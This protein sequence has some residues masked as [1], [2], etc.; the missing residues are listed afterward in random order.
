MATEEGAELARRLFLNRASKL[1][2]HRDA[3]NKARD[4]YEEELHAIF[5]IGARVWWMHNSKNEQHGT[6]LLHGHYGRIRVRN[7]VTH[8]ELWIEAYQILQYTERKS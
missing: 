8:T 7:L 1:K 5:P 6:V 2:P 4:R 3:F